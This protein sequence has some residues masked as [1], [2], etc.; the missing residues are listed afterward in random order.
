MNWAKEN[1]TK[2]E[3]NKLLLTTDNEGSTVIHVV[4]NFF[5]L[6]EFKGILNWAK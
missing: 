1:L 3:V 4:A 5:K 2:E 6:E